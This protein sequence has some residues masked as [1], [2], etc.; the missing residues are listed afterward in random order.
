MLHSIFNIIFSKELQC[1]E[2]VSEV[3]SF[4][5]TGLIVI[6]CFWK[7]LFKNSVTCQRFN[8]SLSTISVALEFTYLFIYLRISHCGSL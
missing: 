1:V 7:S 6:S 3:L 4:L 5:L 8:V 2:L